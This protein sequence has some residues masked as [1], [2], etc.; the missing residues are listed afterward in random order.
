MCGLECLSIW[1]N[2]AQHAYPQNVQVTARKMGIGLLSPHPVLHMKIPVINT[3]TLVE[4]VPPRK[5]IIDG[6]LPWRLCKG[7]H[8]GTFDF[9]GTLK[10]ILMA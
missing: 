3:L 9:L 2:R 5:G 10:C 6:R 4:L 1:L 8:F 7:L